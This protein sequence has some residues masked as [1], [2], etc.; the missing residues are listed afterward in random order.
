MLRN[1]LDATA[2]LLEGDQDLD[3]LVWPENASDVSPQGS[4]GV[5]TLLQG[6]ADAVDA[7]FVLGAITWTG[8]GDEQ[9]YDGL[10]Q[11]G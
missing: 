8:E 7:P 10:R 5:R 6:V 2:P 9:D 4:G 11:S 3:V 1:H